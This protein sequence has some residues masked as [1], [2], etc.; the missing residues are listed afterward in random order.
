MASTNAMTIR[1][2]RLSR[3]GPSLPVSSGSSRS[4]KTVTSA[5]VRVLDRSSFEQDVSFEQAGG[6]LL[7]MQQFAFRVEQRSGVRLPLELFNMGLRPSEFVHALDQRLDLVSTHAD[8]RPTVF[9]FPGGYGFDPRLAH[10]SAGCSHDL[11]IIGISYPDWRELVQSELTFE[12]IV[13]QV[14]GY[15]ADQ[16]P[17]GPLI[18]VGHS[19]G[20]LV[21]YAAGLAFSIKGRPISFLGM[22]DTDANISFLRRALPPLAR[23]TRVVRD[24]WS[25]EWR[26]LLRR[27]FPVSLFARPSTRRLLRLIAPLRQFRL[28]IL[29][30]YHFQQLLNYSLRADLTKRWRSAVSET[31][32][33]TP[34]FVFRA[35]DHTPDAPNDLGWGRFCTNLTVV[36]VSGGHLTMFDDLNRT[37]LC[38]HFIQAVHQVTQQPTGHATKQASAECLT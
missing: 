18:F 1:Q 15:I 13:A 37:L 6:N 31:P 32:L 16:A 8:D 35:E 28:P 14:T 5:W 10:F 26:G 24:F 38:A 3:A 7:D 30:D 36:P 25:G 23:W 11:R 27:I 19:W 33:S 17:S 22:L 34:C 2:E 21:A 12:G 9:L 29:I 4:L 20:G